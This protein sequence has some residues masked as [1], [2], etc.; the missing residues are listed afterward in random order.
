MHR[1]KTRNWTGSCCFQSFIII[2]HRQN[3]Q[4][5]HVLQIGE[6]P[7]KLSPEIKYPNSKTQNNST[8]HFYFIKRSLYYNF[9]IIYYKIKHQIYSHHIRIDH[10]FTGN[11]TNCYSY[12]LF[13][14]PRYWRYSYYDYYY[15][16]VDVGH[17]RH[18]ADSL[19]TP[20]AD[21]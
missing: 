12:R 14:H 5:Q 15:Y 18:S 17:S 20:P 13:H 8:P 4:T 16:L 7:I 11:T 6:L 19:G 3:P 10:Y 21:Q 9:T 2:F 1:V